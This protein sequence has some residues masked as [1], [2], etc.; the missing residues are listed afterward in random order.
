MIRIMVLVL[1][2]VMTK[3][4]AMVMVVRVEVVMGISGRQE[5]EVTSRFA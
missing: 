1:A 3:G 5:E 4:M 2:E